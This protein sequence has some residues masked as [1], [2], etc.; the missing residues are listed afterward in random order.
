MKPA[1]KNNCSHLSIAKLPLHVSVNPVVFVKEKES[2]LW[3]LKLLGA[4]TSVFDLFSV[5]FWSSTLLVE[6]GSLL[7]HIVKS[8]GTGNVRFT[9][10]C[11]Y[12]IPD[13]ALWLRHEANLPLRTL[14]AHCLCAK[15]QKV[16]SWRQI[17]H[18]AKYLWRP[19]YHLHMCFLKTTFQM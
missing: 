17:H 7:S 3:S 4:I 6:T 14:S 12:V 13:T 16:L 15:T 1:P 18:V 10:V 19:Y 9:L 5:E 11:W 8:Y 2:L